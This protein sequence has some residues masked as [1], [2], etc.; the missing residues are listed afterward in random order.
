MSQQPIKTKK[1]EPSL[2]MALPS[3]NIQP[4][5]RYCKESRHPSP[6]PVLARP[7]PSARDQPSECPLYLSPLDQSFPRACQ[8]DKVHGLS[9]FLPPSTTE[10]L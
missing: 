1:A 2:L 6:L 8:S 4:I 10:T 7:Y 9:F 3:L 5:F